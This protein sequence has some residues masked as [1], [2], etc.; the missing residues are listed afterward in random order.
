M[1][2]FCQIYKG[3]SF[4]Q[5][6]WSTVWL[7]SL[8]IKPPQASSGRLYRQAFLDYFLQSALYSCKS[9]LN[10]LCLLFD[11]SFRTVRSLILQIQISN[12]FLTK[13]SIWKRGDTSTI[14]VQLF[15]IS[16]LVQEDWRICSG[17][18]FLVYLRRVFNKFLRAL[19]AEA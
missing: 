13:Q 1:Q 15:L 17:V 16:A 9:N 3:F 11:R 14:K 19:I 10:S 6:S 4:Q 5:E 8:S 18:N 7:I 2:L 12:V